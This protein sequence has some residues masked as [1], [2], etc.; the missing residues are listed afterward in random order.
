MQMADDPA[1]VRF[2]REPYD[3]RP[4]HRV[5]LKVVRLVERAAILERG[6]IANTPSLE[7]V[8]PIGFGNATN[9][10]LSEAESRAL[11][12]IWQDPTMP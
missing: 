4:R 1:S 2:C 7:A 10:K 5:W 12:A 11:N 8:G 6:I 3:P 9:F